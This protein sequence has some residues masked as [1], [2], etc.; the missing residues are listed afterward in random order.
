MLAD[1]VALINETQENFLSTTLIY[2][3]P[4]IIVERRTSVL[5]AMSRLLHRR[6]DD[7]V[8]ELLLETCYHLLMQPSEDTCDRGL[9]YLIEIFNEQMKA[10]GGTKFQTVATLLK[11]SE[12]MKLL[13]KFVVDLGDTRNEVAKQ[14]HQFFSPSTVGRSVG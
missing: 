9:A 7:L 10:N 8:I 4:R 3:I 2:T 5:A 12:P 13:C 1:F 14:V 11:A 6:I